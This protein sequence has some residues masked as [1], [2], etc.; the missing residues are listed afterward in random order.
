[1]IICNT[2]K[3]QIVLKFLGHLAL[4]KLIIYTLEVS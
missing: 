2:I 1:M 4:I 3:L